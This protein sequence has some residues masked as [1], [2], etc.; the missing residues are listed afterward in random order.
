MATIGLDQP[1]AQLH[2]VRH[3]GLLGAG[4]FVF[5]FVLGVGHGEWMQARTGGL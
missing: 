4:E 1:V 3:E 5:C 2:Q